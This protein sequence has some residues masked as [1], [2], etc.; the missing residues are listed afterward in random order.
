M[1]T[2]KEFINEGKF[3][4][5]AGIYAAQGR[6][7]IDDKHIDSKG[8]TVKALSNT[9]ETDFIVVDKSETPIY[10]KGRDRYHMYII[11][12][13]S[14]TI[15][16]DWGSSKSVSSAIKFHKPRKGQYEL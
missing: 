4:A 12:R 5:Q 11:D 14:R 9:G 16:S 10:K 2:Y 15:M 6:A 1:Q 7:G 8:F 3:A 13:R